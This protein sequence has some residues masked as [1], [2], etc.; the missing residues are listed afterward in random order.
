[1]LEASRRA[2]KSALGWRQE[3]PLNW[4]RL[5][6]RLLPRAHTEAELSSNLGLNPPITD[7]PHP[8]NRR[9]QKRVN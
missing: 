3:C 2:W 5:L 6:P 1:L 8:S 7:R 9:P 4:I